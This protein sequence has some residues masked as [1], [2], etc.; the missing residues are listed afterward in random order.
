MASLSTTTATLCNPASRNAAVICRV[1]TNTGA[2]DGRIAT[3]CRW[4]IA[5][6]DGTVGASRP[7]SATQKAIT[8]HGLRTIRRPSRGKTPPSPVGLSGF[9]R[10]FV[11]GLGVLTGCIKT[12]HI[13][14]LL[15]TCPP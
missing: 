2:S 5:S 7:A 11:E 15:R 1:E 12:S 4:E 10:K 13:P 14:H 9:D 8:T 6:R 3:G